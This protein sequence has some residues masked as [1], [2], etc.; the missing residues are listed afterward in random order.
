[1][2][3]IV[4]RVSDCTWL[5]NGRSRKRCHPKGEAV[6]ICFD[7]ARRFRTAKYDIKV[8]SKSLAE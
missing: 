6:E 3:G 8:G 4:G 7:A 2:N 5:F 1:M